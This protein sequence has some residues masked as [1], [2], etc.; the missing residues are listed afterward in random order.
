[1]RPV[2]EPASPRA[3]EAGF[4]IVEMLIAVI[5]VIVALTAVVQAASSTSKTASQAS[6]RDSQSAILSAAQ[7]K[8]RADSSW[9]GTSL[10]CASIGRVVDLTGWLQLRLRDELAPDAVR[11]TGFTISATA[12]AIDS[13]ADDQ[14]PIDADGIVP[15]YYDIQLIVKPDATTRNLYPNVPP[16]T[17]RLQ[18]DF[19][20]RTSGGRLI[21]Q[22]CY[23]WPQADQRIPTGSCAR[24]AGVQVQVLPPSMV[25]EAADPHTTCSGSA[26]GDCDAWTCANPLLDDLCTQGQN[27]QDDFITVR[28]IAAS[29][30]SYRIVG[31]DPNTRSE[32][33][34]NGVLGA[35]GSTEVD[36][37]L[38]GRY[39]VSVSAPNGI[40]QWDTHSV[41]Q[42]GVATVERGVRSRVVQMFRPSR[43]TDALNLPI[44]TFDTS[45]PPWLWD[46][47]SGDRYDYCYRCGSHTYALVPAPLGRTGA[48]QTASYTNDSR[49]L[50]YAD[51]E[52]GLYS[53]KL[54]NAAGNGWKSMSGG[55]GF[56][57][58]PPG[59]GQTM[60]LPAQ[61]MY[62]SH[63]ICI[64]AIRDTY[65][66][67]YGE[68]TK[69][70][71]PS[72]PSRT[73]TAE[74]C[75]TGGGGGGG[76]PPPGG[77]GG[78]GTT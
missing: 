10:D 15:D 47:A 22:A 23:V 12:K 28:P 71:Y 4:G 48:Q 42:G 14:C 37:L 3:R 78:G 13:P 45:E 68:G 62:L 63:S 26:S 55:L 32:P 35:D 54:T 64:K 44:R 49:F 69:V 25:P 53:T 21:I 61:D 67:M 6:V 46:S 17:E 1:M 65:V 20:S 73:W 30:W 60:M 27:G 29:G 70:P 31:D 72:D 24:G 77:N 19:S 41:P 58:V 50:T 59:D 8:L 57:F 38:P 11:R 5:L 52:P 33:D 56:F 16:A 7:E 9:A 2:V 43:R 75:P 36:S 66:A 74:P 34:R 18:L 39:R 51:V 76:A 40:A